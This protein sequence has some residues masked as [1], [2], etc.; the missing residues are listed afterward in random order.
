MPDDLAISTGI[1]ATKNANLAAEFKHKGLHPNHVGHYDMQIVKGW[2]RK[3]IDIKVA[4]HIF[5]LATR[6]YRSWRVSWKVLRELYKLKQSLL[7]GMETKIIK[8]NGKYHHYLYAPGYPSKAFDNYIEGEFNRILR[9]R[10]RQT[11]LRYC[12]L[13][14]QINVLCS[15]SIAWNGIILTGRKVLH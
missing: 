10:K 2:K 1:A 4:I 13:L 9:L 8:I 14:L 11:R 12:F 7:A 3:L 6:N 15:V 5:K